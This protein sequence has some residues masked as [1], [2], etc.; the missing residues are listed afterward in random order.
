MQKMTVNRLEVQE[1]TQLPT[2]RFQIDELNYRSK[3]KSY[4][5]GE[6]W[7]G[8]SAGILHDRVLT[9]AAGRRRFALASRS[10]PGMP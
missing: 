6:E 9:P 2:G 7:H 4:L 8:A 1:M 5:K 10:R 3:G